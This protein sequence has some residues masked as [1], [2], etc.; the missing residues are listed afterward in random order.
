[1][2][3]LHVAAEIADLLVFFLTVYQVIRDNRK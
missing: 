3:I 2:T 1:M